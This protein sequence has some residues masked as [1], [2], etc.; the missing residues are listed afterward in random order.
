MEI[1]LNAESKADAESENDAN[2]SIPSDE[3]FVPSDYSEM[4]SFESDDENQNYDKTDE[5]CDAPKSNLYLCDLKKILELVKFCPRCGNA[6]ENMEANQQGSMLLLHLKCIKNCGVKWCSQDTWQNSKIPTGNVVITCAT[7]VTG[8]TYSTIKEIADA[9]SIGLFSKQ[10][11]Y[12][13]Q[14]KVVIPKIEILYQQ[15]NTDVMN[16]LAEKENK[17]FLGDGR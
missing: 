13:I 17:V 16:V 14:K 4:D 5:N 6:I 11:F 9:A 3:E 10:T 7:L 15:M 2:Q 8:N 12:E 1:G